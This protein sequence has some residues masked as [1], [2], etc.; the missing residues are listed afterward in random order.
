MKNL[1]LYFIKA[2]KR[3]QIIKYFNFHFRKTINGITVSIPFINGMGISNYVIE[4]D[5]LDSLI[6]RFTKNGNSTFVDVG[7][8]LGQT[9]IR[10]KTLRPEMKYMG[11]EPNASCAS[12]TQQLIKINSFRDCTIQ[13]YGL[14][15]AIQN[16]I[17]EKTLMDDLRGSVVSSLRPGYF[18]DREHVFAID[19]DS[20]Y[21]NLRTSFIK[22]DVEGAEVEVIMGMKQSIIKYQPLIVCEVLDSHDPSVYDF[23]QSRANEL[24]SIISSMNFS[25]IHLVT[26]R[27][28]HKIISF[29][30]INQIE[31]KQW[32]SNSLELND[33]LFYPKIKE[34]E[35]LEF[36]SQECI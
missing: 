11:F 36:L 19:Y 23:T 15:S 4:S 8:N 5:W 24:S 35:L 16:L 10:V 17:L 31:I 13:N 14:S 30:K 2:L 33:Y 34:Y 12:Y 25:I 29:E 1:K 7:V 20:F 32:T 3:I 27:Q 28:K 22:I 9:M 18:K 6:K 26:S 21:I